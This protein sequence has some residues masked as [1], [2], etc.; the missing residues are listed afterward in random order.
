MQGL[1]LHYYTLPTGNWGKKGS[2]T[3]FGETEWHSTLARRGFSR[4][5]KCIRKSCPSSAQ[6]FAIALA[7]SARVIAPALPRKRI[8]AP[9]HRNAN[10][11]ARA[12]GAP[13]QRTRARSRTP[14][15]Q[16]HLAVKASCLAFV[17]SFRRITSHALALRAN[18][19]FLH[20]PRSVLRLAMNAPA[21]QPVSSFPVPAAGALR[22]HGPQT[23]VTLRSKEFVT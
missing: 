3:E 2:A 22:L 21:R 17:P 14:P 13:S 12:R 5:A 9:S 19:H 15:T 6:S 18:L 10:R 11:L 16:K 20:T 1:S 8:R 7:N 4:S 23:R